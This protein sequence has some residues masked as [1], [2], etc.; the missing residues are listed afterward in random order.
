MVILEYSPSQTLKNISD[1]LAKENI[2][3]ISFS[4]DLKLNLN[5][6]KYYIPNDGHPNKQV[7]EIVTPKLI[8]E[9]EKRNI[10]ITEK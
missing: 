6:R 5:Q 8:K 9:L 2:Q 4:D 3:I 7:W 1:D 10:D